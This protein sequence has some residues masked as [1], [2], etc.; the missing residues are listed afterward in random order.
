MYFCPNCNNVFDITKTSKQE[1]GNEELEFETSSDMTSSSSDLINEMKGG[2]KSDI[3]D[4]I[5]ERI[6]HHKKID[7]NE[8]TK[9][10]IDDLT[11]SNAYKKL[12]HHDREYIYNKFQ[13]LLPLDKKK[14]SKDDALKQ[15][16]EKAYFICNNCGYLKPIDE[17]TLI[18]SKVSSDISQSYSSS[19]TKDMIYSDIIPRTRKYVCPNS[20]CESH[21]NFEKREASFFRMNNTF[22][23]KY[24]CQACGTDFS[25]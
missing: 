11:K 7:Q 1:G 6:L 10:S 9:I 24:V 21:I 17:G 22:K 8:I 3:Y 23:V 19:D 12:K 25:L 18:F 16:I 15:T 5:I 2:A 14:I 4:D 13:D 20:K